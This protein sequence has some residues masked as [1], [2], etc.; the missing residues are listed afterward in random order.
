[1][2]SVRCRSLKSLVLRREAD[3]LGFMTDLQTENQ[4]HLNTAQ[5]YGILAGLHGL[6]S[7]ILK[8]YSIHDQ[9]ELPIPLHGLS[10]SLLLIILWFHLGTIRR[11]IPAADF[12]A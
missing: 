9:G 5:I 4:N 6:E 10:V 2:L 12:T 8:V 3:D 7:L 1:M 11:R